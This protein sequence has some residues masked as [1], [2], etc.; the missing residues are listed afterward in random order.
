MNTTVRLD[1]GDI[2]GNILQGYG[3]PYCRYL[4]VRV[5]EPVSAARWLRTIAGR[6]ADGANGLR[7]ETAERWASGTKPTACLNVGITAAGLRV[8]GVP[9]AS[10]N[11]LAPEFVRG[12]QDSSSKIGDTGA[13]A[14]SHWRYGLADARHVHMVVSIN[15]RTTDARDDMTT[16][17]AAAPGLAII[18]SLDAAA[19]AGG[20]VHFGY[21]DGIAQPRFVGYH[22]PDDRDDDQPMT[23]VG[24]V[25][26]GFESSFEG[27]TWAL[28]TPAVLGRNGA[29]DAFRLLDQ[30][31]V[32]F[33][34]Y[35]DDQAAMLV[36]QAPDVFTDT[37][38]A[39]DVMLAKML[40]RWPD[41]SPVATWPDGP[42]PG[43]HGGRDGDLNRFDFA[44]DEPGARC[45]IG[46]HI[47][48]SNPRSA[49]IVQRNAA[50][51][52]RLVRR[53]MPY[54][55]QDVAPDGV[56]R[57]LAGNFLCSSLGAQFE[58]IMYDW[59]NLG[60]LDP[61]ITGLNDPLIGNNDPRHSR[62]DFAYRDRS[63][64]LA[65]FPRFVTTAGSAYL[66]LPSL[67]ALRWIGG[68][69]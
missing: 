34:D 43:G 33:S 25:L 24:A 11:G 67:S 65:G 3:F 18:G 19:F 42:A 56:P 57:G 31:V 35:L 7:I 62:F 39:R 64:S 68:H 32:G 59:V 41:G 38:H 44:D 69:A 40:G 23:S 21:V 47:R 10:V 48:R 37:N 5:D 14:P 13:S 66:F 27:L 22:G 51:V 8:L 53:G 28:P 60:L 17:V 54:G 58:A 1:L 61:R 16:R 63:F 20:L 36:A 30:D 55:P 12:V 46:S 15:A 9:D 50:H 49:H 2:Q 26:L 52:R 4:V 29:Y 45:P 6:T